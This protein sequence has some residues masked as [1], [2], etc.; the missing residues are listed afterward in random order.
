ML[1]SPSLLDLDQRFTDLIDDIGLDAFGRFVEQKHFGPGEQ[2]AGDGQL[3]L[4]AA[5]EHAALALQHF[6]EHGK[7]F[8]NAVHL[9]LAFFRRE[10]P[11]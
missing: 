11:G 6:L 2:G 7:Q 4:L 8:Q 5:A 3:L 1:S 10:Q 9:P